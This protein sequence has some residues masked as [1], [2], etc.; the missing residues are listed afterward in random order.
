MLFKSC[1]TPNPQ[2]IGQGE[3]S[4]PTP[5]QFNYLS[6]VWSLGLGDLR[7]EAGSPESGLGWSWRKKFNKLLLL[8][9]L[10]PDFLRLFVKILFLLHLWNSWYLTLHNCRIWLS[11]LHKAVNW[12]PTPGPG[13]RE[14][15]GEAPGEDGAVAGLATASC[16]WAMGE[17]ADQQWCVCYTVVLLHFHSSTCLQDSQFR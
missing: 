17:P 13:F 5:E 9:M 8:T 10:A 16:R 12:A 4:W 3:D 6:R 15:E 7:R 14:A 11:S 2:F 1:N